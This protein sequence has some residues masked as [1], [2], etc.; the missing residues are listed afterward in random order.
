MG[1]T[2]L[3]A[4]IV[5]AA[6]LGI[7]VGTRLSE[8][9][10]GIIVGVILGALTTLPVSLV[11]VWALV[12]RTGPPA[13]DQQPPPQLTNQPPVI[14]VNPGP[15]IGSGMQYP[16]LPQPQ[17]QLALPPGQRHYRTIGSEAETDQR[18]GGETW[19]SA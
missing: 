1:R 19:P 12:R 16:A 3:I 11:L 13:A 14:V 5:F 8:D 7:F 4:A 10:L 2:L 6:I 17:Q 9:A 15:G 18:Y